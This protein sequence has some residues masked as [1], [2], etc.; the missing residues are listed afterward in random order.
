MKALVKYLSSLQDK[1]FKLLP[2]RE[3]FDFGEQNHVREY[4]DHLAANCKGAL[5]VYPELSDEPGYLDVVNNIIFMVTEWPDYEK[6][7]SMVFR[8]TRIVHE[9]HDKY[10]ID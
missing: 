2:M 8:S 7:R 4:A 10:S 9:L 3:S 1:I 5:N 6:W